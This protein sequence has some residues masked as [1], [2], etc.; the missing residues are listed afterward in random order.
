MVTL[1]LA[2][3]LTAQAT[4]VSG[5]VVRLN[6]RTVTVNGARLDFPLE[7][8]GSEEEGEARVPRRDAAFVRAADR[9]FMIRGL[10]NALGFRLMTSL[11]DTSV[12][13]YLEQGGMTGFPVAVG[14]CGAQAWP[15]SET[16]SIDFARL[17]D[18]ALVAAADGHAPC[19]MLTKS[20]AVSRFRTR[21]EGGDRLF[22][23]LDGLVWA[24]PKRSRE[25]SAPPFP[26]R[27]A[28]PIELAAIFSGETEDNPAGLTTGYIDEAR[29]VAVGTH[30]FNNLGANQSGSNHAY[31]ICAIRLGRRG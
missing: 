4:P 29:S 7:L 17:D 5:D 1:L 11:G 18:S 9:R 21:L 8:R 22:E 19:A 30:H 16:A 6:C 27:G 3:L 24:G 25:M 10:P 28:I 12:D 31:A 13:V 26:A 15:R 2:G 14:Y 23:P 20:G